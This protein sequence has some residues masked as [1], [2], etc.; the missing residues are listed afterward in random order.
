MV[1]GYAS[2]QAGRSDRIRCH[3]ASINTVNAAFLLAA[4]R[5]KIAEPDDGLKRLHLGQTQ[6]VA[7][8]QSLNSSQERIPPWITV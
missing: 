5:P 3:S 8:F 6:S 2:W 7:L 1:P 4:F